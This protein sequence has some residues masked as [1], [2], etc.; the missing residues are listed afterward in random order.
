MASSSNPIAWPVLH[1]TRP[2]M[3]GA[4]MFLLTVGLWL[5]AE[6]QEHRAIH[7]RAKLETT[8]LIQAVEARLRRQREAVDRM[9]ER[10]LR[11]GGTPQSEWVFD[12]SRYLKEIPGTA[13]FSWIDQDFIVQWLIRPDGLHSL[14]DFERDTNT[15]PGYRAYL[16]QVRSSDN[17][18]DTYFF[19]RP[20]GRHMV[21]VHRPLV[22]KDEYLGIIGGGVD[23]GVLIEEVI[24]DYGW[25]LDAQVSINGTPIFKTGGFPLSP[26][27]HF[28]TTRQLEFGN[29]SVGFQTY[30]SSILQSEMASSLPWIVLAVGTLWTAVIAWLVYR[31]GYIKRTATLLKRQNR[32]L[33]QTHDAVFVN[34]AQGRILHCNTGAEKLYGFRKSELVGMASRDLVAGDTDLG[35][36]VQDRQAC[37]DQTNG[38]TGTIRVTTKSG[39]IRSVSV[40]ETV[41]RDEQGNI[42]TV[43]STGRD[44]TEDE[45]HKTRLTESESKFRNLFE[46][47]QDGIVI[48][49]RAADGSWPVINVNPAF[50]QITGFT[51]EDVQ[52]FS[53]FAQVCS[54]DDSEKLKDAT[55]QVNVEGHSDP[56]EIAYTC[57]DGS[58]AHL[59]VML[60]RSFDSTNQPS[61]TF[62]VLRDVTEQI[63]ARE[64]LEEAQHIARLG[65]WEHD[66]ATRVTTWSPELYAIFDRDPASGPYTWDEFAEIMDPLDQCLFAETEHA[67]RQSGTPR[68]REFRVK[69]KDG[70]RR[71]LR[72]TYRQVLGPDGEE[73]RRIG[74]TQDITEIRELE[75]ELRHIQ[76]LR[77]VGQLT[78][79][80]AHD[81]NN[82][83]GVISSN[84]Q[85]L[86]MVADDEA[87]V[88]VVSDRIINAVQK[89]AKLTDQLLSFSRKQALDAKE[90][91]TASFL[92]DL[93]ITLSRTLGESIVV[94]VDVDVDRPIWTVVADETQLTNALINLAVNGRDAMDGIGSLSLTARNIHIDGLNDPK[95]LNVRPGPYVALD[96]SDE[97]SGMSQAI[98][99]QAL[100]PFFTTKEVGKGTGLGLSMV[101]G[102]A[103]QSEGGITLKS[104][105]GKG[106]TVTLYLPASRERTEPVE[107]EAGQM[108]G[109]VYTFRT[110]LLV[111]DQ[112]DLRKINE[113]VLRRMGHRVLIADDAE[114]ALKI[115]T[116]SPGIDAAFLDIILPGGMNGIELAQALRQSDPD[117]KILFTSGYASQEV[118]EQLDTISHDGLF[119]KPINITE[120]K[121]RLGALF[122]PLP[123]TTSNISV[124]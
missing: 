73:V 24:L 78:G 114:S 111:E 51:L 121:E 98:L 106:T 6:E 48:H 11:A 34:D 16:E 122:G 99:E 86:D 55:T 37:F 25:G 63:K 108:T 61:Q 85:Y 12:T 3:A 119:R 72:E 20:D 32:A 124:A 84:A 57:K 79:G 40:S 90:I 64:R 82:I 69:T 74:T 52:E 81:F 2:F 68:S 23:L 83:L 58:I 39:N 8:T 36:L 17:G 89:G 93:K 105:E 18:L 5:A 42:T 26:D 118:L 27:V 10:W 4:V 47:S 13:Y 77:T 71:H 96:V 70:Q 54:A 104:E 62:A 22:T 75:E 21:S 80:I 103:E 101:Y 107:M 109:Q 87:E 112:P 53:S 38:W 43:V 14:S 29:L 31:E 59:S 35:A 28:E 102:F 117:L 95:D 67:A 88:T 1:L 100:E 45:Y 110:I 49:S 76:K 60:W 19:T 123:G 41:I 30:P 9:S 92:N 91:D 65:S 94:N 113:Q 116:M 44:V 33:D 97:G 15:Y 56:I 66:C 115:A 46:S 120:V 50:T 7:H